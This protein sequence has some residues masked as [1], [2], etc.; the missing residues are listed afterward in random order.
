MNKFILTAALALL[1]LAACASYSAPTTCSIRLGALPDPSCNP[2]LM[3]PEVSQ[4]NIDQTICV[5][6]YTKTIRPPVSYTDA[7]KQE[8]I[9][10]YGYSDTNPR[11]YEEDHLVALELGGDPMDPRNLWA[12]P[13]YGSPNASDKDKVENYLHGAVCSHQMTLAEAQQGISTNWLQYLPAVEMGTYST[14]GSDQ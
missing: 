7:Q 5:P 4:D 8:S 6:G 14:E 9:A 2:G 11:D 13:R 3:N 1:L 10:A 12:E